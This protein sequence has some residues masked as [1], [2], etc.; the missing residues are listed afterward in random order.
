LLLRPF[1]V[2][3]LSIRTYELA[4]DGQLV[5]AAIPALMMVAIGLAAVVVLVQVLSREK[6][7][8]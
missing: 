7:G 6:E 3:T 8:A 2:S 5:A 1:N 4:S